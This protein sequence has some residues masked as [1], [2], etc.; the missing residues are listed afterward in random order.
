MM[1]APASRKCSITT[2]SCRATLSTRIFEWHV[3]GSPATSMMSF[4]PIGM[5]C[6]GPR[7]APRRDLR[8]RHAGRVHRGIGIEA[9]ERVQHRIE[10]LDPLEQRW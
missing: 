6:S 4:T 2:A 5:P 8:L 1:T 7:T 3:V 10:S 9:D